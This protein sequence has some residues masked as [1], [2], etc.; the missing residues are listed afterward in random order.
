LI[1]SPPF[2]AAAAEMPLFSS[3][4]DAAYA[5]AAAAT[6]FFFDAFRID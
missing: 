5:A 4:S 6:R 2:D 1:F 3:L